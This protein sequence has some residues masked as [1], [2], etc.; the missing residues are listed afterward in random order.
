MQKYTASEI[1][2][3]TQKSKEELEKLQQLPAESFPPAVKELLEEARDIAREAKEAAKPATDEFLFTRVGVLET[4]IAKVQEELQESRQQV[5]LLEKMQ[6]LPDITGSV[7]AGETT[8]SKLRV[9]TSRH[10]ESVS[11]LSK[12]L[13]L[14]RE[15]IGIGERL[16]TES[17]KLQI[18]TVS[19]S[20]DAAQ[21]GDYLKEAAKLSEHCIREEQRG[22]DE[23][24]AASELAA[25]TLERLGKCRVEGQGITERA[26]Q[27]AGKLQEEVEQAKTLPE[28]LVEVSASLDTHEARCE[29]QKT[30]VALVRKA[31]TLPTLQEEQPEDLG[32]NLQ[33]VNS[34]LWASLGFDGA[35]Q[36]PPQHGAESDPVSLAPKHFIGVVRN[37]IEADESGQLQRIGRSRSASQVKQVEPVKPVEPESAPEESRAGDEEQRIRRQQVQ[38]IKR[39][40][41]EKRL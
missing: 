33:S 16:M 34:A 29:Q 14:L 6:Q 40:L 38:L 20:K 37:A 8:V 39:V 12:T 41:S 26:R 28:N 31:L 10:I 32:G 27:V 13:D 19:S 4:N 11:H 3:L 17:E 2:V 9:D 15:R 18:Q 35:A 25:S 30:R 7:L 24:S 36:L 21:I 5:R 23:L 1:D 22:L